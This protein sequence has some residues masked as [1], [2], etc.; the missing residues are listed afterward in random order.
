DSIHLVEE[1]FAFLVQIAF[2]SQGWELVGHHANCPS[3]AIRTA[4]IPPIHQ[5]FIRGFGLIAGAE[6]AVL[7]VLWH[8]RFTH[9]VHRALSALR[10]N[11]D[12]AARNRVL[13]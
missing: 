12:P 11:D 7:W 1:P 8:Y 10:R 5:N 2:D 3:G 13:P 9:K 6:R 4:A